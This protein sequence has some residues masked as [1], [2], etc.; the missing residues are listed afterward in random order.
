MARST[1]GMHTMLQEDERTTRAT[2]S[3][4]RTTELILNDEYCDKVI[5]FVKD[6]QSEIRMCAYA[7]RWYVNEP[8]IGIQRLN[9]ELLRA[10]K[11]GVV[12][13]VLTDTIAMNTYFTTLGFRC[14]HVD[15]TKMQHS[16][17]IAV[18]HKTLIVGSH[19]FTKRAQTDNYEASIAVQD[20]EVVAQFTTYF[21]RLWETSH[22]S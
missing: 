2:C 8:G 5:E 3:P 10:V 22:D 17:V 12:V 6:A 19:N 20:F 18:D 16:K 4:V 7:W 21:D 11:R 14:R 1:A 9:I 15:R 13:R